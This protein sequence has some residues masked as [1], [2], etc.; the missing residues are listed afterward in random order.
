MKRSTPSRAVWAACCLAL[1][2]LALAGCREE[3][4][5]RILFYDKGIYLG[6]PDQ[7]LSPAQIEVLRNRASDQR[8]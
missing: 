3:E 1:A 4:H 5:D 6:E 7:E 8:F 2:G